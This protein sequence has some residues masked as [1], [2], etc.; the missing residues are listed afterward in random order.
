MSRG[1]QVSIEGLGAAIAETLE[2]YAADVQE[3]VDEAGA[4]AIDKLVRETRATAP[5][6]VR[7]SK[8]F[9]KSISSKT[10]PTPTGARHVWYVK[11]PNYRLTHLLVHGHATKNGGRTSADPFLRNALDHVLPEYERAIEEAVQ[12]D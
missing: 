4:E 8:K 1:R 3:R 10:L 7:K 5:K 11:A 9:A 6:G 2:L 12:N